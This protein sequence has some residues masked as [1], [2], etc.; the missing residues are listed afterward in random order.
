MA[1]WLCLLGMFL[2]LILKRMLAWKFPAV[3]RW[4]QAVRQQSQMVTAL[5]SPRVEAAVR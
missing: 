3:M 5:Q 1:V 4:F 2:A